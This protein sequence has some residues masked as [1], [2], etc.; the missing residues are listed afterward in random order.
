MGWLDDMWGG[1]S[2][3]FGG[4]TPAAGFGSSVGGGLGTVGSVLASPTGTA[5]LKGGLGLAGTGMSNNANSKA[6]AN[7]ANASTSAAQIQADAALKAAGIQAQSQQA[8]RDQFQAAA[9]RGIGD[10]NAGTA[11]Y[12]TTVAPLLTPNPIGLP[13]YRGLSDA[14][15]IALEDLNRSGMASLAASGLRGA[16]RAGVGA[17]MDQQRRFRANAAAGLDQQRL[18]AMQDAQR[19]ADAARLGLAGVGANAGTAKANVEI[20]QGNQIAGS[21]AT[22]GNQA[23][24]ATQTAGNA[25]AGGLTDSAGYYADAGLANSQ[26][27]ASAIGAIGNLINTTSKTNNLER[28]KATSGT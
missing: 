13:T 20:G 23:A 3:L 21:L 27:T 11:Q 1:V 12:A 28:Y 7:R 4:S 2:D 16:G 24:L 25:T 19:R 18:S 6:A 5:L 8:A 17:L 10:I 14:Q 15:S 26:N 22:Q 9:A